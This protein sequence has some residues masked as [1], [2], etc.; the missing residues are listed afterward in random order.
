MIY[1]D[2]AKANEELMPKSPKQNPST[3]MQVFMDVTAQGK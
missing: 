1:L 2:K 3:A